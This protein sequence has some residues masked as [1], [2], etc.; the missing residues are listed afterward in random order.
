M[1][2]S[3]TG[4]PNDDEDD[5]SHPVWAGVLPSMMSHG[6]PIACAENQVAAPD[7]V[8]QWGSLRIQLIQKHTAC[9][10]HTRPRP[11][12]SKLFI[13]ESRDPSEYQNKLTS[14]KKFSFHLPLWNLIG[15]DKGRTTKKT[16]VF[17]SRQG[18][19]FPIAK[20]KARS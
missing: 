16:I 1:C 12:V 2:K 6:T 7:Y 10:S 3:R 4:G 20:G 11:L 5:M 17:Q 9:A 13:V 15:F 8:E 19:R 14:V 18:I